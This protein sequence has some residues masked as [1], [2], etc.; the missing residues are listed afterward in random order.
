MPNDE[1]N[2][3]ILVIDDNPEIHKDF[4]KILTI[5]PTH[6]PELDSLEK[7]IFGESDTS[8]SNLPRFEIDTASQG[9]EGVKFIE[10]AIQEGNH[11]ALA[12]VDIRMPPGWDGIETIKHIWAIDP[13][14][15]IV[16]C[17]AYSDY[18]WEE[19]VSE[20]GQKE[21][22]LILKKPF[23]SVAVRQLACALTNKWQLIQNAR[24]Y[25]LT[26]ERQVKD[27][28]ASLQESLSLVRATLE[29]SNEGILVVSNDGKIINYNQKLISMWQIPRHIL[30]DKNEAKLLEHMKNQLED[31]DAFFKNLNNL[32]DDMNA[33]RVDII[34]F[35]DGKIFEY[36]TQ[37]QKIDQAT[38]GRIFDFRDITKRANLEEKLKHQATHDALTELPNRVL[39]LERIKQAIQI[40]EQNHSIFALLFLDLDRFKLINDSL[41][42]LV[43]DEVLKIAAHRL[44]AV[45]R[46]EDTLAR[47]GGDEFVILFTNL[48]KEDHIITKVQSLQHVFNEPFTVDK[49]NVIVTASIGISV[50]PKDGVNATILLR[51]ADAAMYRAKEKHGNSFQFYSKELNTQSLAKLDQEM[52]LR[53]AILK[54]QFFLCYQ[55]QIDLKTGKIVA[56]E[57]LL[58]WQHPKKGVLLPLDFIELTEETGLIIPIGEWVLRKACQQNKAWQKSGLSP[59]RVAVNVTAQQFLHQDIVAL[60]S[61]ILQETQLKPEY[62]EL[63]LTENVIVSNQEIIKAVVG[64]KKL[65]VTIAIDDFGT[66]YS[67]L[68]YLKKIPL[69]RLKIDSSFIQHIQSATDDEVIIRAVIAMAKNLD[70]E[71]I[72]EGVETQ[73]QL[74]FL[75][76]HN[77]GE[78]QG[79]YFSRPLTTEEL[80]TYLKNPNNVPQVEKVH[81]DT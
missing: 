30:D 37:P 25:T 2:L 27:R 35:N 62:L 24:K 5:D 6:K 26:L 16:I 52:Q 68:S 11:Y 3:R 21:N 42:H 66:G 47:L 9:Q 65:G 81:D 22:L 45:M 14:I 69:D 64:L 46:A 80:E 20:L 71:V 58:R 32:R 33:T 36:Y 41:S 73:N 13:D 50:Y 72:T 1:S 48:S 15:Q 17:T 77:C 31:P 28:T 57:A 7:K 70:L 38:I 43:G 23:D 19:T 29:S 8:K 39:L 75:K 40:S 4:L 10:K 55:P 61:R 51:N 78:V 67:S 44:Q 74:D 34:R 18:S 54:N 63:E 79:F 53:E 12:F 59:I 49:R 76:L 56:A 60:V